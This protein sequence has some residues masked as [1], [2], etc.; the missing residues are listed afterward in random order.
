[1]PNP[2]FRDASAFMFARIAE[3][4]IASMS[5]APNTGVGMGKSMFGF[6]PWPES[7][8]PAGRKLGCAMSQPA[9]S[10]RPVMAK[11]SCTPPSLVPSGL[12]LKRASRTGPFCVMNHG[13]TF[14]APLRVAMAISGFRAGL[15]PPAAGCEWQEKHW[16]E[17]KR[18]PSPLLVPPVTT[19]ISA[20][21]TNPSLK[22]AVSSAVRP[23]RGAPAP[24]APPRT[25]GS[26]GPFAVC[27]GMR[28]HE[29][30][31]TAAT[32]APN[33]FKATWCR[34]VMILPPLS[35]PHD[36]SQRAPSSFRSRL[37]TAHVLLQAEPFRFGFGR[38][39]GL[40]RGL[41]AGFLPEGG[42]GSDPRPGCMLSADGGGTGF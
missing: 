8:F 34:V 32:N 37:R 6:P 7:G 18:G 3:S 38:R 39:P 9:A 15:D 26:T 29:V 12:R 16:F 19:S 1:M 22:N 20:N 41:G 35:S 33:A 24:A 2:V 28:A 31:K 40:G 21:L 36:F 14:F 4:E 10:L 25:P 11:R 27:A 30:A 13:T 23:G 5:P 17:L 42:G